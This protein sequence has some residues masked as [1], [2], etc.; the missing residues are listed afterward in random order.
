MNNNPKVSIITIT[1]NQEKYIRDALDSFIKQKTNF[2][3]EVIVADD[4]STDKTPQI[5]RKYT[6]AH[7][8][9][10]KP[11]YRTKNMGAAENCISALRAASGQYIALCEGD[12]YWT[13]YQKLQIQSD[14]LDEH[15]DCS[16]CFHPVKVFFEDNLGKEYV[17]PDIKSKASFNT[18]ELLRRNFIQTNSVMYRKLTYQGIPKNVLPLDWYLHLYH[19]QFGKIGYINRV[20]ATYRRHPGGLWWG[21]D[22]DLEGLLQKHGLSLLALYDEMIKLFGKNPEYSMIIY[23][24]MNDL[25]NKLASVDNKHGKNLVHKAMSL[26]PAA[27]ELLLTYQAQELQLREDV[28]HQHEQSIKSKKQDLLSAKQHSDKLAKDLAQLYESKSWKL[29]RNISRVSS[30]VHFNKQRK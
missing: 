27:I 17:F 11:I 28:I 26:Y 15:P 29:A 20:M 21:S 22:R 9:L 6:K 7:P 16:L 18:V 30:L 10:F 19:A 5:I 2:D 1:Y 8:G 24:R 3:F 23:Y 12:D 25:L 14:Y 13:D 4:C